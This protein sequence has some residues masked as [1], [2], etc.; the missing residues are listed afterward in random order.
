MVENSYS[1]LR[2]QEK[3]KGYMERRREREREREIKKEKLTPYGHPLS[4][5]RDGHTDFI[6]FHQAAPLRDSTSSQKGY[7]LSGKQSLTRDPLATIG[8]LLCTSYLMLAAEGKTW[9]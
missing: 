3:E 2:W 4:P 5:S 6:S 8:Y 9:C 7:H 1:I